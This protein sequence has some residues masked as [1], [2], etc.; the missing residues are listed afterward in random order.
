MK[1][2]KLL[3]TVK[4]I[5]ILVII[6]TAGCAPKV[7]K[8][9]PQAIPPVRVHLA[10]LSSQDNIFFKGTY[11]LISEEA[12]YEFAQRNKNLNILPLNQG[13]QLFNEN[14][15]LNFHPNESVVLEPENEDS[16]FVF[17]GNEYGG[18]IIITSAS[19]STLY[20]INRLSVGP[21]RRRRPVVSLWSLVP[22][23]IWRILL[24]I[25]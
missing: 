20:L 8:E 9:V 25:R 22:R 6:I 12:R 2:Q 11:Y 4:K 21:A 3:I 19:D 5:L 23:T 16:R 7:K 10:T 14:R 17:R 13:M 18:T 24:N 15:N 1:T